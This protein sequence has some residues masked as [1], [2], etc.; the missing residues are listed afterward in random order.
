MLDKIIELLKQQIE[1]D[2][3]LNFLDDPY[4]YGR[5]D[6]LKCAIELIEELR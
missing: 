1:E 5:I 3:E 6:G 2:K 4:V